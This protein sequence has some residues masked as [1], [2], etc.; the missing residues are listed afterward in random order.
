M[1]AK[2]AHDH[3]LRNMQGILWEQ[4]PDY[5]RLSIEE[6]VRDE[7]LYVVVTLKEGED[8]ERAVS[9]LRILGYDAYT[10][11]STDGVKLNIEW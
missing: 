6:A 8:Y 1:N 3:S 5:V 2:T 10:I 9:N 7:R 11:N 4:L